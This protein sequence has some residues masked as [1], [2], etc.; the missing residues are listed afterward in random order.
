MADVLKQTL[1]WAANPNSTLTDLN[2]AGAVTQARAITAAESHDGSDATYARLRAIGDS[3]ALE[4][5]GT[6]RV[7]GAMQTA[8]VGSGVAIAFLRFLTRGRVTKT[9]GGT[10]SGTIG[11]VMNGVLRGTPD[12]MGAA[13]AN[14]QQ[15]F[16]TDPADGLPWTDAKIN[17]QTFGILEY[18]LTS[19][20]GVFG[21]QGMTDDAEFRI[22]I[23]G[24]DAVAVT[25]TP[26]AAGGEAS[27]GADAHA[28]G[29]LTA[30]GTELSVPA[31]S[32]SSLGVTSLGE[33]YFAMWMQQAPDFPGWGGGE[34]TLLAVAAFYA[35]PTQ[36][37]SPTEPHW[38]ASINKH[39]YGEQFSLGITP[40]LR[41][42]AY[43]WENGDI[44]HMSAP[45]V[46]PIDGTFHTFS[47]FFGGGAQVQ[48]AIDGVN[49]YLHNGLGP[50]S[51]YGD[52]STSTVGTRM[53][54]F[55][56]ASGL[57]NCPMSIY[58][59]ELYTENTNFQWVF[60][61]GHGDTVHGEE[62]FGG[63]PDF[64][65]T[66][67]DLTAGWYD[68]QPFYPQAWGALPNGNPAGAYRWHYN[69]SYRAAEVIR[70]NYR[71]VGSGQTP[72]RP[73]TGGSPT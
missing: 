71:P 42:C 29:G 30:P 64:P 1:Y 53:M 66:N 18:V 14:F 65:D 50:P 57:T 20:P 25:V 46:V 69:T 17:A 7:D 3:A 44:L 35:A 28:E 58:R 40:D 49:V 37:A 24:H 73:P 22:E 27:A 60:D 72:Y 6:N 5:E 67:F 33:P 48:L 11:V 51:I 13:F 63:G 8:N 62:I 23:W 2:G 21:T 59:I 43:S 4:G 68:P 19:D 31:A 12:A 32:A 10:A 52:P 34:K 56:G 9:G 55:N 15:D 26:A 39:Q 47:F 16:A 54:A 36:L 38:F 70:P 45:G 41:L 61:E